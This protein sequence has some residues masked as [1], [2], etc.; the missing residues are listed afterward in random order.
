MNE[1]DETNLNDKTKFRLNETSKIENYFISE[2]N[3]RKICSK[4]VSNYVA[5]LDYIE[6]IFIV[7]SAT[8]GG[9]CIIF[10]VSVVGAPIGI[11]WASF[12]LIFSLTTGIIIKLLR[13]TR[14]KKKKHDKILMLAKSK[15]NSLEDLVCQVLINMEISHEEFQLTT[16]TEKDKCEKMK[17]KKIWGI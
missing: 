10:A 9:V 2:I 5:A 15:P 7:L 6:K 3:Q 4:K 13:I 14:N 17:E 11:A 16:L 1:I 12:T 8:S